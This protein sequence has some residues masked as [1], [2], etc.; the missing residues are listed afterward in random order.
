MKT[1]K[2][3]I[4]SA[5]IALWV[6]MLQLGLMKRIRKGLKSIEYDFKSIF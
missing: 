2:K 6:A 4:K 1:L 3:T 5:S